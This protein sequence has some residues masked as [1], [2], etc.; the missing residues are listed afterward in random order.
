MRAFDESIEARRRALELTP[1]GVHSN[2][3]L[4][5]PNITFARGKGAWLWD[6][7]GNDY[8]DYLL[9]QGPNFFG[10]APDVLNRSVAD[11]MSRGSVFGSQNVYENPAGEAFLDTVRWADQVRFGSSGTEVV[12][13]A[14]RLARALT[15][16]DKFIRFEGHYHGWLDNVLVKTVNGIPSPAS[17]GQVESHLTDSLM[18]R[19]N[20]LEAVETALA[21]RHTEVA[22]VILEPVMCNIGAI[23]PRPGYLEGVRELCTRY[24][25]VLIFDEVV[26]GFRLAAGGAAERFGVVPDLATFGKAMAGGWPVA[27]LAGTADLMESLGTG[28][29]NHSGTFNASVGACA[30]VSASLAALRDDPPY[31]RIEAHGHALM[32]GLRELGRRH[33]VP[34]RVQGLPMAFH[35]SFGDPE[36]VTNYEDLQML[37]LDRYHRFAAEL[38]NQGV[39]VAGRGVWYVSTTHA[40]PELEAVLERVD[41]ALE[42]LVRQEGH[43]A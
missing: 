37:D 13:V 29:V 42:Q 1:G 35:V 15:G 32:R 24:G 17:K 9:G 41:G 8:V 34:L 14:L 27:A 5:A 30:A 26:T 31:A 19:F 43:R 38:A 28:A 7:D 33:G 10:H 21:H 2:V 40:E 3:R 36:P 4:S 16:R 23:P 6:V 22:A 12:Q 39:W 20:D 18:L 11:A 25:V